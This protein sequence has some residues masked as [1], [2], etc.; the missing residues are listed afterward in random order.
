MM[1]RPPLSA[2]HSTLKMDERRLSRFARPLFVLPSLTC[3]GAE[4]TTM[5]LVSALA[6]GGVAPGLFVVKKSGELEHRLPGSADLHFGLEPGKPLRFW[7]PCVLFKLWRVAANY[8][9]IVGSVECD[10]TYWAW[11][12]G[13]LRRR[14]VIGWVRTHLQSSLDRS[15]GFRVL[16][17][18]MIYPRLDRIAVVSM[19]CLDGLSFKDSI[20]A[21]RVFVAKPPRSLS[22]IEGM[23]QAGIGGRA[24]TRPAAPVILAVGRLSAEK[25]F[26]LL[27]EAHAMLSRQ[28]MH[29][30]LVIVGEGPMR[31]G[32][33]A[34]VRRFDVVD[35]VSLPG[36]AENPYPYFRMAAVLAVSSHYEGYGG[37]AREAQILGVPVVAVDCPGG[38]RDVLEGGRA[39]II[40]PKK[41]P[42]AMADAIRTMLTCEAIRRDCVSAGYSAA[43]DTSP[44]H[45][46]AVWKTLLSGQG[47]DLN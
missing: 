29:N 16:L 17:A 47:S 21:G 43:A 41:G 42:A 9:V 44:E 40:V 15:A 32:L 1:R 27:I 6:A 8:D 46:T 22:E 19:H 31:Q 25:N 26:E 11:I 33:E 36:Y 4:R 18:R 23:S 38:I 5:E 30:R 10:V 24:D 45:C 20:E 13:R 34:L 39:G 14:R 7:L 37:V 28:G 12:A 2:P 35:S 3:G